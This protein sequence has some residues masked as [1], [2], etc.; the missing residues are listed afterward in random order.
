[1]GRD[2]LTSPY[3]RFYNLAYYL[4]QLGHA[5]H[6]VCFSYKTK[7]WEQVERDGIKITSLS[8]VPNP[9]RSFIKA[10][11]IIKKT[12]SEWIFGFS[13]TYYGILAEYFSRKNNCKCLI[14][15]YD[16]YESYMPLLKFVHCLWRNAI[17]NATL[18]T[19]AGPQLEEL[20]R[21]F[22]KEKPILI[23]PMTIDNK[24]F[25]QKDRQVCREELGLP[26]DKKLIGF[27]GSIS[28]SRGINTLFKAVKKIQLTN[29]DVKLV[30]IGRI[31]KNIKIPKSVL[32]LGYIPDKDIVN[33]I[34]SMNILAV[35]NKNTKFGNYSY[36][37]KLYEAM[38]C[39]VPVV[40]SNTKSTKWMM[41]K[42]PE[43]LVDPDDHDILAD[44][45][46]EIIDLGHIDYDELPTWDKIAYKLS[47]K[48]VDINSSE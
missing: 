1:M 31:G 8:V 24:E 7:E 25:K 46:G 20:F 32:Y 36:P 18:V 44:K 35:I 16:N 30:L 40:V 41:S 23:L 12:Q 45:I 19:C 9:I 4:S 47:Q 27:H 5:V 42:Y 43:L 15:A 39:K 17:S 34:N 11:E 2:L 21:K 33:Y 10:K 26:L 48:I 6:L 28:N 29:A 37:I 14:D 22:R 38:A 3:G 13:D